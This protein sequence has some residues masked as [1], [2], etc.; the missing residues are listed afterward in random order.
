MSDGVLSVTLE[1]FRNPTI[2]IAKYLLSLVLNVSEYYYAI[3]TIS[4][5]L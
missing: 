1:V 4:F 2:I 5:K 3:V